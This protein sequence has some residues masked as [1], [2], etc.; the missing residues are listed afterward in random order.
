MRHWRRAALVAAVLFAGGF[1]YARFWW[2]PGPEALERQRREVQRLGER[3]ERR[4]RDEARLRD[5]AGAS[6]L[7]GV[8]TAVAERLAGEAVAGFGAGIKVTLRDLRFRK[9]DEVRARVLLGRRSVGRYV[10]SVHVHEV[11]ALL[12]PGKPRLRVDGERAL[13]T[14]PVAVEDGAGRARLRFKWDGQGM[15]GAVCGDVDVTHELAATLPRRTHTLQ[16]ALRLSVDGSALVA[17][18]EFGDVELQLPIEP[19]AEAWNAVEQ[20]IARRGA[21]CRAALRKADVAQKIR[22]VLARG[23]RVRLPR[24]LL[25][26]P[27]RLPLAVDRELKLPGRA[28]Q[29]YAQ[30]TDLMLTPA[31]IWYGVRV[32]LEA[33]AASI[34]DASSSS[35]R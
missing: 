35:G 21:L 17:A 33:D 12:R 5:G 25:E 9:S 27:L 7:V 19:S 16:G 24:R 10:L 20:L 14:L 4:L 11:G 2:G 1:G 6:V 28:L 13:V 32:E 34:I 30:P 29:L 8:P 23:V 22:G 18:P 31:R 15:A 3:L 26:R